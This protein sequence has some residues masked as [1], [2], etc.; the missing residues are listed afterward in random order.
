MYS[1]APFS[2]GDGDRNC[3]FSARRHTPTRRI[4]VVTCFSEGRDQDRNSG[5]VIFCY[6]R[7]LENRERAEYATTAVFVFV[8]GFLRELKK[9]HF[10]A[11]EKRGRKGTL[12]EEL[13][14]SHA[15]SCSML[16]SLGVRRG[17]VRQGHADSW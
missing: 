13:V 7:K 4:C 1:S 17:V 10:T 12:W 9:M 3:A 2:A 16:A 15:A 6:R 8:S 5:N 11:P 14:T